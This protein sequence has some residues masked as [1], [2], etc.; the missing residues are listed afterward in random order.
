MKTEKIKEFLQDYDCEGSFFGQQLMEF[1]KEN[2]CKII[3][4]LGESRRRDTDQHSKDLD[5]MSDIFC[6]YSR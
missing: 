2:L 3:N 6:K 5:L 4:Y 1:D